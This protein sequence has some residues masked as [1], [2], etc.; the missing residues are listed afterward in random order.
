MNQLA[1]AKLVVDGL[2]VAA[3]IYLAMRALRN[4]GTSDGIGGSA[5]RELRDLEISLKTLLRDADVSSQGLNSSLARQQRNLEQ[6]LSDI[7]T[8]ERRVGESIDSANRDATRIRQNSLSAQVVAEHSPNPELQPARAPRRTTTMPA[9]T[10]IAHPQHEDSYHKQPISS[11]VRPNLSERV[12]RDSIAPSP[13]VAVNVFG[14]PIGAV[15]KESVVGREVASPTPRRMSSAQPITKSPISP[16][17]GAP[18]REVVAQQ[19]ADREAT[20]RTKAPIYRQQR[21]A[22]QVEVERAVDSLTQATQAMTSIVHHQ[23][24]SEEFTADEVPQMQMESLPETFD[25]APQDVAET[26]GNLSP[27]AT[28]SMPIIER[29]PRLGVLGSV[30]RHTQVL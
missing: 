6:L 30:R 25:S 28:D 12:S 22:Q 21:L 29:D 7:S 4:S 17:N 11:S 10:N 15:S 19:I 9:D 1:L 3:V 13:N 20:Q 8:T 14:E 24:E 2:L 27:P 18:I 5:A 26:E 16:G 23:V